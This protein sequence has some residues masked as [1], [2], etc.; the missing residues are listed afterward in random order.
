MRIK[1]FVT[2]LVFVSIGVLP[3][4]ISSPYGTV[5][6]ATDTTVT[7]PPAEHGAAMPRSQLAV[8]P[9]S[10][11]APSQSRPRSDVSELEA[12]SAVIANGGFESGQDGSWAEYSTHAWDIITETFNPLVVPHGGTW[13]AWLGGEVDDVS[14]ISQT[15][16]IPDES[17]TLT[18]W[19][20]IASD[21]ACGYD[22]AWVK[23]NNGYVK[24]ID[25][26]TDNNT[27]GWVQST[28]NLSAYAGQ[29]VTLQLRVET[30]GT[31]NSNFFVD[32]IMLH[33]TPDGAFATYLPLVL[34][35][36]WMGYSDD[37][38]DPNSGWATGESEY[39]IF[40]Y[41]NGEYRVYLNSTDGWF[42]V[43]PGE[44]QD[45]V[46]PS[47]YRIEADVRKVSAGACSY[48]LRFG[49]SYTEDAW[50]A[51]QII[52]Y[53]T[54]GD[55][56]V[57]KWLL[58]GS[59]VEIMDWTYASAINQNLGTNHMTVD[60]I[61]TAI[62]IHINGTQVAHFTD[63]SLV[64]PGRDAGFAVYTYD[65]APADVRFDNFTASQP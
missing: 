9:G 39:A 30:D 36:F 43:T 53:P 37:F 11:T 15:V 38:S 44:Q 52:I 31:L 62:T 35:N 41:L 25:L 29:T 26:C 5:R 7:P 28:I 40:G 49:Q 56:S 42:G 57:N 14:Y 20:W 63:D 34:S 33:S 27:G 8:T 21:D 22:T 24:T 19:Q 17:P 55:F 12:R 64:G 60:R 47:D 13:A 10:T 65:E 45:L 18:Y 3:L 1:Q 61:G 4:L 32:D 16:S 23:I 50:E 2:A 54:T 59:W 58:D 48:G 6:A 51:Y 46:L